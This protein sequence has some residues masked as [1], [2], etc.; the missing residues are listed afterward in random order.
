MDIPKSM[1]NVEMW[2]ENLAPRLNLKC[3]PARDVDGRRDPEGDAPLLERVSRIEQESGGEGR[4]GQVQAGGLSGAN[5]P[6]PAFPSASTS[7][8]DCQRSTGRQESL[9]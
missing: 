6:L 9:S 2:R 1:G 4:Q 8:L 7:D 3:N 5:L